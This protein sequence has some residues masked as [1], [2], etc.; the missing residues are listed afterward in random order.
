MVL[1]SVNDHVVEPPSMTEFFKDRV[2]AKFRARVP[3]VIRRNDG[4]AARLINGKEISTFGLN[5]VQ[6]AAPGSLGQ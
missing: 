3:R 5:A 6:G 2:P 1:I 4:T